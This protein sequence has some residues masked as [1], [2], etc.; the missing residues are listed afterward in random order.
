MDDAYRTS[1]EAKMSV[2]DRETIEQTVGD[3]KVHIASMKEHRSEFESAIASHDTAS[4]RR[5]V[6]AARPVFGEL[7]ADRKTILEILA[8]YKTVK[9]AGLSAPVLVYPNPVHIGG[10]GATVTYH[11]EHD[12]PVTLTVTDA[13]GKAVEEITNANEV[14]GDHT[15]RLGSTLVKPGAYYINIEVNGKR[16]SQKVAAVN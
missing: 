9:N 4:V 11:V 6:Q 14:A 1:L 3:I 13:S 5:M 10:S 8:K 12:G 7:K 16:S 15:V 2:A